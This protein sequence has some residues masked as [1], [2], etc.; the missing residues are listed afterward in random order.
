M[1]LC[2]P[3]PG[4]LKGATSQIS[5]KALYKLRGKKTAP[6]KDEDSKLAPPHEAKNMTSNTSRLQRRRC[7][8]PVMC[9]PNVNKC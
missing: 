9:N 1:F 5:N 8:Q 2:D 3:S 4:T 7:Q 6:A